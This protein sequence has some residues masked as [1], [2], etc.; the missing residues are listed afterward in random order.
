MDLW[1]KDQRTVVFVTH[2]IDEA[3]EIGHAIYIL[4]QRP[5]SVKKCFNIGHIRDRKSVVPE[6]QVLRTEIHKEFD[7]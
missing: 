3:I 5:T 7:L 2:E 1:E 4:G 6:I